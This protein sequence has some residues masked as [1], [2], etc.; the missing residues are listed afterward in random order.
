MNRTSAQTL[1]AFAQSFGVLDFT[2]FAA[3][4]RQSGEA[5]V[6]PL[7]V[8]EEFTKLWGAGK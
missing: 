8:L 7:Y 5:V 1:V 4:M 3:L 6:R 2:V